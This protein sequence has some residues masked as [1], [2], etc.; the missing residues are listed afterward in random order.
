[1]ITVFTPTYNRG[2]IIHKLYDSLCRQSFTN[3]EWVVVD[4]GSTDNTQELITGFIAEQKIRLR[5]FRQENA[6][7]HIAINRGVQEAHGELFFIVDSDDY[8]T[9][10]ALEKMSYYYE[11]I[12]DNNDFAGISGVRVT[13][14]GRRIG[15]ELD[16]HVK[17]CSIIDFCCK[18]GYSGDMAEAYKTVIMK[19][20]PFPCIEHEKF[21]PEALVWNRIAKNHILRYTNEKIY[22]CE[23]RNDGLTASIVKV[24]MKSP[25]SSKLFYAEQYRDMKIISWKMR[26]ALNY[27]R[28]AFCC[29][30]GIY[31]KPQT[32]APAPSIMFAPFGYMLHIVDVI[33]L[34]K[35]H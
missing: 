13:P 19:Q 27:W 2:Y 12:K 16:F 31:S 20:N 6:G 8:L 32:K 29:R 22:I 14:E 26:A 5:Y 10:D 24:R 23:Y 4:D 1:M 17:D 9:D 21:C 33:K 30:H 7:K 25:H 35:N 3:F 34:R 11:Q 28:F 18:F 15:G